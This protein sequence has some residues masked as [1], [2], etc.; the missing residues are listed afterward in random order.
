MS[1]LTAGYDNPVI[2]GM[3]AKVLQHIKTSEFEPPSGVS[4]ALKY[5]VKFSLDETGRTQSRSA[6]HRGVNVLPW[7][8]L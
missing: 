1:Q 5:S 3:S 7:E 2:Q 8:T 4:E 6:T